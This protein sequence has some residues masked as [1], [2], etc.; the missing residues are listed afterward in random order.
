MD[1]NN[2]SNK[3]YDKRNEIFC[4]TEVLK[5]NFCDKNDAQSLVRGNITIKGCNLATEVAFKNLAP[6]TKYINKNDDVEDLDLVML[7]YNLIEYTL[8]YLT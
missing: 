7:M 6:F 8:N 5:S 2:Q 1:V 4:N 3:S